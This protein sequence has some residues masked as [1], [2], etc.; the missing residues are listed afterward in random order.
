MQA[1]HLD[2]VVE[3]PIV[4]V[5][6]NDNGLVARLAEPLQRALSG[7]HS[8]YSVRIESVG[9]VGEVMVSIDGTKGR[10]P[11]LFGPEEMDAGYVCSVVKE[12]VRRFDI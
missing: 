2:R 10:I 9:R 7:R 3:R 12:T 6:G 4:E 11:L 8:F 5:R 1:A